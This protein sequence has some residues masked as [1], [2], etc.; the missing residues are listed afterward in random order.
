MDDFPAGPASPRPRR[1]PLSVVIPVN[2][3]G[4]DFE[5][6]LRGLRNSTWTDYELVVVDD[7]STDDSAQLA[8]WFGAQVIRNPQKHGPAA[9]RNDGA[10][11]ASAPLLFFVDADV[12]VHPDAI[13][14]AMT[15]FEADP[16]L[17]ALFGSYDD[18]PAA[19]GLVSRFRNLL[20]HYVHQSGVFVDDVRPVQTFWTG[21]GLIRREVFLEIGGFDPQL[22]RRP[23]IEDIELGY[24]I[25]GAGHRIILA[26]DVQATHLK[27]WTL[28]EMI[29]TDI[30]RRGVPWMLLMKRSKVVETD[31]NV[32]KAQRACVAATGLGILGLLGSPWIPALIALLPMSLALIAALNLDFY[33]FLASRRGPAFAIAS[34]ALHLIYY[35]C[36]G[37]S[38]L[39]AEALWLGSRPTE[40]STTNP[41]RRLDRAETSSNVPS[42]PH[43]SKRQRRSRTR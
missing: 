31:L 19:P 30:F 20:H 22:Y 2:N 1:P 24:R 21:C 37:A 40:A 12:E 26:R 29:R 41:E 6:C 13:E 39:I 42:A 32:S 18:H 16:A 28:F 10:L 8:S 9:A 35:C 14:R 4:R 34:T 7:G 17:T 38:V 43:P 3:G 23:A 5:R 27:R 25:T 33:R 15:R 36:C 11:T